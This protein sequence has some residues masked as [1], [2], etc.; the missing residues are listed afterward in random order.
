MIDWLLTHQKLLEY[1]SIPFVSGFIGW[2]TNWVA[3]KMTFYPLKFWGIPPYLGWQGIIPRKAYKMAGRATDMITQRLIKVE[4][5]FDRVEPKQ[6]AREMSPPVRQVSDELVEDVGRFANP[7]MWQMVPTNI[8]EGIS[9]RVS[10]EIEPVIE[11]IVTETKR[12]ILQLF[13]LKHLVI[14]NLTGENVKNL[15]EMFQRCGKKEFRFIEI[16]GFYFGFLFGIVQALIWAIYAE[17]WTLPIVG[18]IVGY[19]TNWLALKMIFRPLYETTYFGFIK[20]QGLFLR[21]QKEVSAEYAHLVATRILTPRNI[22]ESIIYGKTAEEI[23]HMIQR[24]ILQGLAKIEG[25]ARPVMELMV[26]T[27]QYEKIRRYIVEKLTSVVPKSVA[28]VEK[29]ME[30]AMDLENTLRERMENLPP[31]EFEA[32]LRTAFQEDEWILIVVGAVLGALVGLGQA[33]AFAWL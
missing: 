14:Q 13:D 5:I 16:S 9:K 12:N 11:D 26:G 8:K 10:E 19:A 24:H 25:F 29:Y 31:D 28:R 6:M 32:L 3:I 7:Q 23:F 27:E 2:L 15:N 20:Y 30:E 33:L 1:L 18:V 22:L 21:R 4:E 17:P